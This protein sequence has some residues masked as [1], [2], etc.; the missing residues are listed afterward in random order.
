MGWVALRMLTGNRGKFV[1]IIVG[2]TFA[3]LLIAQQASI[4]CGLM[5]MTTSQIRDI[6]GAQIWVMDKNVQFID[7]IKPMA[8]V[9]LYR[10][11]GVQGV[12]WAVRLY[13]GLSR[14]RLSDGTFQQI[15]LLGIDDASMVGAPAEMIVGSIEDLRRPDAIIMD[16]S[17]FEQLWP[18][19]PLAVGKVF[20]MND[21]RAQIVGICKARPTFQT[22]PV[23]YTRYS[24]ATHFAPPERKKMS[25][26]LANPL[27]GIT[28]QEACDRITRQTGLK[29][30]TN[31]DF[32]WTTIDY[33]MRKTGIPVNFGITVLLGF[34]VGTAIAGQTFYLF[35][36]ENL[37][38][39]GALK[40]M[41]AGNLKLLGM[42]MLQAAVVALLGYALG[43]G[44]AALF[45]HMSRSSARVAFYMP[46]A[47]LWGTGAAVVLI[48]VLSSILSIRRVMVLEPAVVFQG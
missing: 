16:E 25:F 32:A 21:R 15:I 28:A 38:Q 26:V 13:K 37:R 2:V 3:A 11:R 19:E 39:F 14:A 20:E 47:V 6:Q 48:S 42:I 23:V 24:Q 22:F 10:V 1:G 45:G 31:E 44:L 17:G 12:A 7:D 27:P 34:V 4:F 41:G 36:I 33:Y 46:W 5:L 29:A 18:G 40:A 30:I 43:I 35:T 8:D 9:E